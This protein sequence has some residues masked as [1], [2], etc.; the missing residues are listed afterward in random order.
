MEDSVLTPSG[1]ER[2]RSWEV[3]AL[4]LVLLLRPMPV[5]GEGIASKTEPAKNPHGNPALCDSCHTS[6]PGSANDLPFNGNTSQLCQSCHDGRLATR[7]AHPVDVTPSAAIAKKMPSDLPLDGGMLTCVSCHNVKWGCKTGENGALPKAD[8]LRGDRIVSRSVAF[9]FR[10]HVR[11]DYQPSNAHDQ[12]KNGRMNA[13]TCLWCHDSVPDVD[14]RLKEGAS[15]KLRSKSFGVC[16]NCHSTPM[17][18]P[19]QGLHM[20]TTLSEEMMWYMSAYELQP[21]IRMPFDRLLEYARASKRAARSIPLDE[22]N[23]I[24]CYSCHNPHEKGVLPDWNPRSVGAEPK[25]SVNHRLRAREKNA[26][27]ACHKE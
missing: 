8:F 11:E 5:G 7:A 16:R 4:V 19:N 10:C 26:C 22:N 24:T 14:S 13:D 25:K 6:S 3:A 27:R 18:H 9:C 2:P 17:S 1:F 12:L 15:Y 20:G 23:R 21:R